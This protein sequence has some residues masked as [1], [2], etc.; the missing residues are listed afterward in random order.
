M[1]RD[2]TI[3]ADGRATEEC[4]ERDN[5]LRRELGSATGAPGP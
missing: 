5:G 3:R 2:R 1:R 4:L